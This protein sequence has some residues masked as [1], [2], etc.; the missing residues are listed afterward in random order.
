MLPSNLITRVADFLS[1]HETFVVGGAV[2]ERLLARAIS[3]YDLV[4]PQE[5]S[6]VAKSLAAKMGG[7]AFPLDTEHG[8]SRVAFPD[9]IHLDLAQRQGASW[10]SD[11]DRRD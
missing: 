6:G 11:L 8:I 4:L 9:N 1:S 7:S 3:D 10:E 5:P 2:R